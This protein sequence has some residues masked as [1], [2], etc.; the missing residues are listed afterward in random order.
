M[1]LILKKYKNHPE[2]DELE[3]LRSKV[4]IDLFKLNEAEE[5]VNKLI[6]KKSKIINDARMA[7]V[8]ILIR[9]KNMDEALK[10]FKPIEG[11]VKRG[12]E[13]HDVLLYFAFYSDNINVREEYSNLQ[14]PQFRGII[15]LKLTI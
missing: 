12:R 10:I 6:R 2:S 5:K 7:K 15:C 14:S 13:Y 8:Q 4:L 9:K 3:L 1:R 11:K